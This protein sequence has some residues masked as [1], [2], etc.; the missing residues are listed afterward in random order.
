LPLRKGRANAEAP[1]FAVEVLYLERGAAWPEKGDDRIVLPAVDLP[2]S[3]TGLTLHHSP[4]YAIEPQRGAFRVDDDTGP[5]SAALRDPVRV[6]STAASPSPAPP[7]PNERDLKVLLDQFKEDSGRLRQGVIPV[8]IPF[9]AMG[10]SLFL[11]SELTPESQPP[12]I[13]IQ[14]RAIGGRR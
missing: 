2:I 1:P 13:D 12:A 7:P 3:R 9:P 8:A 4:R 11:A 14:V 5:W 10:T 6:A